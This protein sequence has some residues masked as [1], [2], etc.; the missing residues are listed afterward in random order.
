[1]FFKAIQ[2]HCQSARLEYGNAKNNS[3]FKDDMSVSFD[4]NC[5]HTFAMHI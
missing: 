5:L 2:I 3:L 4:Y 1:M